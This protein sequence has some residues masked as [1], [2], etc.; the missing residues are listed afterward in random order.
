MTAIDIHRPFLAQL[1]AAAAAA[2]LSQFIETRELSMDALDYPSES[3]DL[4]WSEGVVFILGVAEALRLWRPM[5]KPGGILA[6]T[7]PAPRRQL[8]LRLLPHA[9]LSVGGR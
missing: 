9:R 5:L 3:V 2:G 8:R 1:T 7:L 4:M 6:F